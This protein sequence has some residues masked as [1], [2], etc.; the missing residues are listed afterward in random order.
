VEWKVV[1][2]I[3]LEGRDY[4]KEDGVEGLRREQ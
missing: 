2:L 1:T 3:S 4:E